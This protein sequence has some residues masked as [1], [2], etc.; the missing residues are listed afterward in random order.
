MI[1]TVHELDCE[2]VSDQQKYNVSDST[3]KEA[4]LSQYYPLTN[5]D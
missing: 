5:T 1:L 2:R 3:K 4:E